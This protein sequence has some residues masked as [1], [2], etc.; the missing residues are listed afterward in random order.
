MQAHG[1][2]RRDRRRRGDQDDPQRDD[3]GHRGADARMLPRRRA[4][5][6]ARR[7]HGLA[8]EQLSRR[9]IGRR[10]PTT[11]SSAWR[12]TASGAPPRWK[13]SAATLRELGLDPL[14]VEATVKRQREMGSLGKDEAVRATLDQGRAAMLDAI[15]RGAK[16]RRERIVL[17]ARSDLRA[18]SRKFLVIVACHLLVL[19]T[20]TMSGRN[21][22][23]TRETFGYTAACCGCRCRIRDRLSRRPAKPRQEESGRAA[24]RAACRHA[25]CSPLQSRSA[26]RRAA[27]VHLLQRLLRGEGR[28]QG[29]VAKRARAK[30][31]RRWHGQEGEEG[32]KKKAAKKN[33][34]ASQS[35][36]EI[37]R[38]A[39]MQRPV[40]ISSCA[41]LI[42]C[43]AESGSAR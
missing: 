43:A 29:R 37:K 6:R 30:R 11:T 32:G 38:A 22:M 8:E 33:V 13:K 14:M 27:E 4:R 23:T 24:P 42:S 16:K 10:S 28:R 17:N 40:C 19:R 5:R 25:A 9:S 20:S 26:R 7:G 3:Q 39:V 36:I 15:R 18:R 34:S 12:A 35:S 1:R 2:R 21:D 31:R 41:P